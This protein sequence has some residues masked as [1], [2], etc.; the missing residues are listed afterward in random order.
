LAIAVI[1]PFIYIFLLTGLFVYIFRKKLNFQTALPIALISTTLFVFLFTAIFHSITVGF[2]I[3]VIASLAFI[4][5]LIRDKD[6]SKVLREN[7]F[8]P[9]FVAFVLIYVFL[10]AIDWFKVV[11]LLSDTSMHWAPHVW[12]MW[13]TDNFY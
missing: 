13:L 4:P 7:I 6:R 1:C 9:G 12:T 8:T 11:P 5:L 2:W 3:T 10:V